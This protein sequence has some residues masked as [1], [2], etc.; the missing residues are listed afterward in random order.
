MHT[1]IYIYIYIYT[2]T[3]IVYTHVYICM[4]DVK[5]ID[6]QL[7]ALAEQLEALLPDILITI[8]I[9]T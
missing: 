1:Y 6:L 5:M 9:I 3:H 2:H 7:P 8:R 4:Y